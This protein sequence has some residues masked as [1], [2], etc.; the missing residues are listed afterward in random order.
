MINRRYNI[1]KKI[2]Q[3]RS[4]VFLCKDADYSD[5]E[6]AVKV[7]SSKAA[8]IEKAYFRSEY[9][10]LQK[11]DHP[12]IIKSFETGTILDK[13]ETDEVEVGSDF[14]TLEYFPSVELLQSDLV[15][16]EKT[17]KLILKQLCSVLYY[18]HQSNYIYYDLKPENILI[19]EN[20]GNLIIKLIDLGFA[21]I[22]S[23]EK[24]REVKG[25]VFYIAPEL[26]KN[27]EHDHRVDLYSLGMLLYSIIYGK[28]PFDTTDELKIYK[29]QIETDFEFPKSPGFSENFVNVVKKL[30][31]KNPNDRY[32]NALQ[33]LNELSIE[34]DDSITNYL[35]P[36][37][38]F[39]G[40]DD[41]MNILSAYINDKASSEVFTIKGFEGAGKTAVV[42]TIFEKYKSV[43]KISSHRGEAGVNFIKYLLK[44]ILFTSS[45]HQSFSSSEIE[46]LNIL[47]EES[48][49]NF[50]N[51]L[52]KAVTD[53]SR[54]SKF[55][56]LVD[57]FNLLDD[58]SFELLKTI[59]QVLQ[60]NGIKI[61]L[62]ETSEHYYLSSE[63][64]NVKDVLLNSFTDT[65]VTEFINKSYS[66]GF[67]RE[68]LVKLIFKYSDFL[69]GSII[70]FIKDLLL[71][72][73]IR[74]YPTGVEIH[75]DGK[76][77][78]VLK[79]SQDV[80]F[81]FRLSKMSKP[82]LKVVQIIS[83]LD[84]TIDLNILSELIDIPHQE[85]NEIIKKLQ[86]DNALRQFTTDS[87]LV[88]TSEGFKKHI[89]SSI[90]NK[91]GFHLVIAEGIKKK[92]KN[93]NPMELARQLELAGKQDL[94]FEVYWGEIENIE[95]HSAYSYGKKILEHLLTLSL[96]ESR[97][98]QV[99]LKLTE[100][101]FKLSD[102]R[103]SIQAFKNLNHNIL[104]KDDLIKV[105]MIEGGSLIGLGE[106]ESGRNILK[107]L[108]KDVKNLE[109]RNEIL[110]ELAYTDFEQQ[111][112]DNV[113]KICSTLLKDDK[114]T[115][116]Q[117]GRS[118]NLL[119]MCYIYKSN[120][121]DGA[122]AEFIKA[123]VHY[124]NA[125]LPRRVAGIEVNIGNIFNILGH[126]QKAEEHWKKASEINESV[127]NLEQEGLIL[128]NTGI[129]HYKQRRF[130]SAIESYKQAL[131]IFLSLG[132]QLNQ[133]I[134]N[135]N[136]AEV[137]IESCEYQNALHSLQIA[138][139]IF[140]D[141]ENYEE[142]SE[143][144]YLFGKF[145]FI[146][147][148]GEKL[149]DIIIKF[150]RILDANK[151]LEKHS[152][153][154]RYLQILS[155]ILRQEVVE[156]EDLNAIANNLMKMEEVNKYVDVKFTL[157][158]VLISD[159]ELA[160]ALKEI[161]DESLLEIINQN[162]ILQAHRAFFLFQ[163]SG[164]LKTEN[165]L[166]QLE[167]LEEA[168]ELIK[169]ENITEVTWR[170]LLSLSNIY[171]ERGNI[172]KAKKYCHYAEMLLNF[173]IE[174]IESTQL[175]KSYTSQNEIKS[176]FEKIEKL[177]SV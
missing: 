15:N 143:I 164:N 28:F 135:Y 98:N 101:F 83:A 40:R 119:A 52:P 129:Y 171:S 56:L 111:Q 97:L 14:I 87:S 176:A 175:R 34:I 139:K 167:Y 43:V 10:T 66:S 6:I 22:K 142:L 82:E 128:L 156:I 63:L 100:I 54:K 114:L 134:V 5:N 4:S 159:N 149:S 48:D 110:I 130:E 94:S 151:G 88:I 177:K 173:I 153:Y 162:C 32:Q 12:N 131:K 160:G 8:E 95:R 46:K 64:N 17:L 45:I 102:Y 38:V 161:N 96:D 154:L 148:F 2:G 53:I 7:L 49:T 81:D 79:S 157:I 80:L 65:Q 117:K 60:I 168:Y 3:G 126:S 84:V 150:S 109:T 115:P 106:F 50:I 158:K 92:L 39:S 90:K 67:P 29:A 163:I 172:Q 16:D 23:D 68:E 155:Q 93:F 76:E 147:G 107:K 41:V 144:L 152:Y 24:K 72:R 31:K 25:T 73:I 89:Y 166:S 33:V 145:Y 18:L 44:E 112:Y 61:I 91:N 104:A 51:E 146:L 105:R 37:K 108:L 1:I 123:G 77:V 174:N 58:L 69:P 75:Q 42:N 9:F 113:V 121:L 86:V 70:S 136:L 57:A 21:Q 20:N 59:I 125:N 47:I 11:L 133:G 85:I 36:V 30:L 140:E 118:H 99:N 141:N 120:D 169:E 19:A 132:N 122:L 138:T 27:E 124:K 62:A 116:E 103:S 78:Q 71:L 137:Y 127:G 170:V 13:N 35:L 165:L 55:I 74:Y 26:L